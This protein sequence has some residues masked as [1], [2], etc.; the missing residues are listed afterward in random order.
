V[1]SSYGYDLLFTDLAI[2]VTEITTTTTSAVS[3]STTV[4]VAS[5]NG[6]LPSITT[7][8]GLGIDPYAEDPSVSSRSVTSGAGNLELSAAQ[9]LESGVTLT[10][11]GTGQEIV[12]TGNVEILKAGTESKTLYFDVEKLIST[13]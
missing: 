2:K 1:L 6:V 11:N 8:S 10:Y 13:T 7:V 3:N 5:V 12:I 4:P 9:T